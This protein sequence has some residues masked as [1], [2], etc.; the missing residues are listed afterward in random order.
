LEAGFLAGEVLLVE[1]GHVVEAAARR[2]TLFEAVE[3]AGDAAPE[4][5]VEAVVARARRQRQ[6]L[7]YQIEIDRA[8]EGCLFDL[9]GGVLEEGDAVVLSARIFNR[10]TRGRADVREAAGVS[11]CARRAVRGA[12]RYGLVQPIGLV[13]QLVGL[14]ERADDAADAQILR[15]AQ[16]DFMA[17]VLVALLFPPGGARRVAARGEIGIAGAAIHG[18]TGS[19]AVALIVVGEHAARIIRVV[20]DLV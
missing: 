8:E 15:R 17:H 20:A 9:A 12:G 2:H 4:R 10:G 7:R 3:A 18:I 11:G 13:E 19:W 16:A 5:V 14:V 6:H 1:I